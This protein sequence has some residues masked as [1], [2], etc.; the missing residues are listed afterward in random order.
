MRHRDSFFS[1][2]ADELL[3]IFPCET[4][5]K[6]SMRRDYF[7]R[8]RSV[9][10]PLIRRLLY[11]MRSGAVKV[12]FSFFY[13]V[14]PHKGFF[15]ATSLKLGSPCREKIPF[16]DTTSSVCSS[17]FSHTF[18]SYLSVSFRS[19]LLVTLCWNPQPRTCTQSTNIHS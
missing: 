11:E 19:F 10:V 4:L 12:G 14:M 1:H 6:I 15:S 5:E 7:A 2:S 18:C 3:G 9:Y 17:T 8:I 16:G 13:L